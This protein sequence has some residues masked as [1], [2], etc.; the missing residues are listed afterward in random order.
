M[1]ETDKNLN[2]I[3]RVLL[4]L[5][6]HGPQD[7]RQVM[8]KTGLTYDQVKHAL[9]RLC[10]KRKVIK[11]DDSHTAEDGYIYQFNEDWEPTERPKLTRSKTPQARGHEMAKKPPIGNGRHIDKKIDTLK[12][13]LT[14]VSPDD[15]DVLIGIIADYQTWVHRN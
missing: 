1:N 7:S 2:N 9:R 13:L 11:T 8:A 14:K 10:I 6:E 15:R 5:A 4:C 12:R 3:C